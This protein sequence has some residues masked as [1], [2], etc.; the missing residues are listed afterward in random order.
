[1]DAAALVTDRHNESTYCRT[2]SIFTF[3]TPPPPVTALTCQSRQLSVPVQSLA[4][5]PERLPG[6]GQSCLLPRASHYVRR[7]PRAFH[8]D[9]S[10]VDS[11]TL[12][13]T[14]THYLQRQR[15][16]RPQRPISCL[17]RRCT[18]PSYP[19]ASPLL[20]KASFARSLST[21]LATAAVY[22]QTVPH[23]AGIGRLFNQTLSQ[24]SH[25][26]VRGTS[27]LFW[28]SASDSKRSMQSPRSRP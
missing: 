21:P 10:Q 25:A 27:K 26:V 23:S 28:R 20:R 12:L 22:D 11:P 17:F 4:L 7:R 19:P 5:P 24:V 18:A 14:P 8:H 1:M 13:T 6:S 3:S 16:S 15:A 9:Q 2:G